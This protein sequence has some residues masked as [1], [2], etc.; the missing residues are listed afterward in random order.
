MCVVVVDTY[1]AHF[2]QYPRASFRL[3]RFFFSPIISVSLSLFAS[4]KGFFFLYNSKESHRVYKDSQTA[5]GGDC[6]EER[7]M[8]AK[9]D[10]GTPRRRKKRVIMPQVSLSLSYIRPAFF[11]LSSSQLFEAAGDCGGYFSL[12]LLLLFQCS[13]DDDDD[14]STSLSLSLLF[15]FFLQQQQHPTEKEERNA[16]KLHSLLLLL[17]LLLFV[18]E[19]CV[20]VS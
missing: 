6:E 19:V 9:R 10:I 4:I 8:K 15:P 20:C 3:S 7:I 13:R 18:D 17:L 11:F 14:L 1:V 16:P 2:G 12:L 5:S